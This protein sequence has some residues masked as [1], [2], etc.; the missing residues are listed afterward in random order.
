MAAVILHA[1]DISNPVRTATASGAWARRIM[2][3]FFRQGDIEKGEGYDPSPMCDRDQTSLSLVQRNFIGSIV[4]PLYEA[5][6]ELAFL[7]TPD[8]KGSSVFHE[9]HA[10]AVE[11]LETLYPPP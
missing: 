7:A 1:A 8:S 3:E 2:D 4:A 5:M 9:M 10:R 11:N 6:G